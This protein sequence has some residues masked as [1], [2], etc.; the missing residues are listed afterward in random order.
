MAGSR[1]LCVVGPENLGAIGGLS[2]SVRNL[3]R[4][5]PEGFGL[6]MHQEPPWSRRCS[7]T[8]FT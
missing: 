8:A 5:Q 3:R 7:W 1:F 4:Q 2:A 6:T